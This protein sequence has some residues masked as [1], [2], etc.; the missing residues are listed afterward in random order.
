[1]RKLLYI[2]IQGEIILGEFMAR[3]DALSRIVTTLFNAEK[4][5]AQSEKFMYNFFREI[6]SGYGRDVSPLVYK[7]EN[8]QQLPEMI[9][10]MTAGLKKPSVVVNGRSSTQG[11]GIFGFVLKDGNR[12]IGTSAFGVDFTRGEP[13]LQMRGSYGNGTRSAINYN[14]VLDTNLTGKNALRGDLF[15]DKSLARELGVPQHVIEEL[16]SMPRVFSADKAVNE[17][18][19]AFRALMQNK[20]SLIH[21]VDECMPTLTQIASQTGRVTKKSANDAVKTLLTSM[22]YKSKDV[23]LNFLD[24]K[25]TDGGS[26]NYITGELALNI[27]MLKNHQDLANVLGHEITHME[28]F[29]RLYKQLGAEKFQALVD[30]KVNTKWY[31]KMSKYVLDRPFAFES[32]G[33][34]TKIITADNVEITDSKMIEEIMAAEP[35]TRCFDAN[36]MI[37][38]LR[39]I[40]QKGKSKNLEGAYERLSGTHD[41][42]VSD[43]EQHARKTEMNF[44]HIIKEEG[45]YRKTTH[46]AN[47]GK[48]PGEHPDDFSRLFEQ[49]DNALKRQGGNRCQKFNDLYSQEL[50][51]FDKELADIYKTVKSC[52]NAEEFRMIETKVAEILKSRYSLTPETFELKILKGMQERLGLTPIPER[53]K[54]YAEALDMVD[55]E[56]GKIHR[57]LTQGLPKKEFY[58]LAQKRNDII[59]S[60]YGDQMVLGSKINQEVENIYRRIIENG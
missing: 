58:S 38:E 16:S 56:L 30:A 31:D 24:K 53:N 28:D 49:I 36:K 15:V 12:T 8:L 33:K 47:Y 22:G 60:R 26:F 11:Q 27:N 2:S 39:R 35:K 19:N 6:S 7:G 14:A 1:M 29:V 18:A 13:I 34:V 48:A 25:A 59:A 41:Y 40:N 43:M 46:S 51:L 9:R 17:Q 5:T 10:K 52:T 42:I 20:G 21:S 55:P 54:I 23:K 45:I 37:K 3:I 57:T 50:S 32:N 44:E 4:N